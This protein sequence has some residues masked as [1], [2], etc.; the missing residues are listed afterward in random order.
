MIV[1]KQDLPSS[2]LA[3]I[4]DW[5]AGTGTAEKM[6][7]KHDTRNPCVNMRF[8]QIFSLN[9]GQKEQEIIESDVT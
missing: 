1:V 6:V 3:I 7:H 9:K 8:P 2:S 4:A 5:L